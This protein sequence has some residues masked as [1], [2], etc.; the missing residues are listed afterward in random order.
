MLSMNSN[1]FFFHRDGINLKST[2]TGLTSKSLLYKKENA[3]CID[4]LAAIG[5]GKVFITKFP[6]KINSALSQAVW[7]GNTHKTFPLKWSK[8]TRWL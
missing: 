6:S 4:I 2:L 7:I 1:L 5:K 8:S 3:T